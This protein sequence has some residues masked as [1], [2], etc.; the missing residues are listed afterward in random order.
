MDLPEV[1]MFF[2]FVK[3]LLDRSV[4]ISNE[5]NRIAATLSQMDP[6]LDLLKSQGIPPASPLTH[7]AP[8]NRIGLV[9]VTF[10]YKGGAGVRNVSLEIPRHKLIGISGNSGC[11]KSTCL[12]LLAGL[13][14]PAS[15]TVYRAQTTALLEQQ[16]SLLIGSVKD[17]IL[18]GNPRASEA[19]VREAAAKAGCH[20]IED[21]PLK[22]E[23]V[24]DNP[25]AT[26]FSGG[27]L[28][29]I[30]LARVFISNAEL[31]LFDEPTTGLDP[32]ASSIFLQSALQMRNEG[33][34]VVFA[35][36]DKNILVHADIAVCF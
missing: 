34:T 20:F 35:S 27:Q 26:P 2:F 19:D 11:G 30:C 5:M 1:A 29:R 6:V 31:I 18:L 32:N 22:L 24:I 7:F 16:P 36:H 12:K 8:G 21:L 25:E 15:G 28:Q 10:V 14:R 13:L 9:N 23:T 33:R 3:Q 17:N 4:S